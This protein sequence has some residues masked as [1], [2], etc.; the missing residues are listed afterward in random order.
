MLVRAFPFMCGVCV[1]AEYSPCVFMRICTCWL[2]MLF[3]L[4]QLRSLFSTY[5]QEEC[6]NGSLGTKPSYL[7][8]SKFNERIAEL[9]KGPVFFL[10]MVKPLPLIRDFP[11]WKIGDWSFKLEILPEST[12]LFHSVLSNF[13]YAR[14][15]NRCCFPWNVQNCYLSNSFCLS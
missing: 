11:S 7:W 4:R 8:L 1:Y 14:G 5:N 10:L 13:W 3:F 15:S 12:L 2:W 9:E 6:Q